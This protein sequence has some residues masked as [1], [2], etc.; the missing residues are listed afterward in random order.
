MSFNDLKISNSE[1]CRVISASPHPDEL[2]V[3]V[4]WFVSM[5]QLP[6]FLMFKLIPLHCTLKSSPTPCPKCNKPFRRQQDLKRHIMSVHLPCWIYCSRSGCTWRGHRKDKLKRH[7]WKQ[8]CGSKAWDKQYQIYEPK[9]ILNWILKDQVP[10]G[11]G[12]SYAL[13]LA[14]EKATELRKEGEWTDFW[15]G[16]GREDDMATEL[17]GLLMGCHA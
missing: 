8:K 17:P 16:K 7:L 2:R 6:V 15:G 12:A 3:Q 11:V 5:V 1:A 4:R 9:M 10:V 14:A 13:V